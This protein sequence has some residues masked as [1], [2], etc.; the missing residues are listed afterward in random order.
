[1]RS[2]RALAES[3]RVT[4]Q[5]LITM[6]SN[7]MATIDVEHWN[8]NILF[9]RLDRCTIRTSRCRRCASRRVFAAGRSPPDTPP[10]PHRHRHR[11]RR[12]P[13]GV[14]TH[15]GPKPCVVVCKDR[16]KASAEERIGQPLSR[17]RNLIPGADAVVRAEGNTDGHD[18][19]ERP[20]GQAWST[21]QACA[22]AP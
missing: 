3:W 9:T 2:G 10:V 20:E 15:T 16:G 12:G 5:Q 4:L 1:M 13:E 17:E 8:S 21:T 11:I 18:R 7:C 6:P 19:R 14:A 22:D